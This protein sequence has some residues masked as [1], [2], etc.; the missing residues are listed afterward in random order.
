MDEDIWRYA[1]PPGT[2]LVTGIMDHTCDETG[3]PGARMLDLVKGSIGAVYG[4]WL[5]EQGPGFTRRIRTATLDPFHGYV[6]AIR[7]KLA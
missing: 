7:D 3:R 6:Y 1:R 2:G 5:T 4:D